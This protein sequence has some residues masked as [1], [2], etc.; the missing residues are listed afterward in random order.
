[1]SNGLTFELNNIFNEN[2]TVVG[3][4]SKISPAKHAL[5]VKLT[6]T[7]FYRS[8]SIPTSQQTQNIFITFVQCWT[9]VDVVKWSWWL[10]LPARKEVGDRGFE[11]LSGIQVSKKQNVSSPLTRRYSILWGAS[12]T[13]R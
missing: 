5:H 9:N 11:P 4:D 6:S 1:M 3:G 10:K 7:F 2:F 12:V 8:T 13:E